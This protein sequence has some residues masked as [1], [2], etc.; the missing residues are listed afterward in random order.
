MPGPRLSAHGSLVK[1]LAPTSRTE[2]RSRS[3]ANT[4]LPL[5]ANGSGTWYRTLAIRRTFWSSISIGTTGSVPHASSVAESDGI[6]FG[7]PVIGSYGDLVDD[8]A[9]DERPLP[10]SSSVEPSQFIGPKIRSDSAIPLKWLVATARSTVAV[11]P[12][13]M[14]P[15]RGRRGADDDGRGLE[16]RRRSGW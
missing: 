12:G 4:V 8:R 2:L 7:K 13:A 16:G 6:A 3:L 11:A 5:I 9:A 15:S 10:A 14:S 1:K